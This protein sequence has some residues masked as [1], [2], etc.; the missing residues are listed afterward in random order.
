MFRRARPTV[1]FETDTNNASRRSSSP[2]SLASTTDSIAVEKLGKKQAEREPLSN[3]SNNVRLM[4]SLECSQSMSLGELRLQ[5][6]LAIIDFDTCKMID[7][8]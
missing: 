8:P 6:E 2:G 1:P 3:S 7:V 4:T 5:F